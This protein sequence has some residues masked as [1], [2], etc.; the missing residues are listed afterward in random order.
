MIQSESGEGKATDYKR[1]VLWPQRFMN[2]KSSENGKAANNLLN[3][4]LFPAI[5][6]SLQHISQRDTF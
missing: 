2:N 6:S 4:A 5:H 1:I 3:N